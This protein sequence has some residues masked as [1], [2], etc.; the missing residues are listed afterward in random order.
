[1]IG[2]IFSGI[3]QGMQAGEQ[4]KDRR[5][6]R[7]LQKK[8]IDLQIANSKAKQQQDA[9]NYDFIK[10]FLPSD[11]AMQPDTPGQP[12]MP[13]TTLEPKQSLSD[14][15]AAGIQPQAM[16]AP[17]PEPAAPSDTSGQ[18]VMPS[19]TLEPKQ[20]LLDILA[21]GIQPQ[22]MPAPEP[23]PAAPTRA[24]PATQGAMQSGG[25]LSGRIAAM[26]PNQ[27]AAI[28]SLTN[29]DLLGA[30]RLAEQ[31]RSNDLREREYISEE[32]T[33]PD[34][35]KQRIYR[36]KFGKPADMP[37][38]S[39][40]GRQTAPPPVENYTFEKDGVTYEVLR[41]KQTGKPI[42]EPKIIKPLKGQAPD[43]AAKIAMA[44][45]ALA[46]TKTLKSAFI[47]PDG[48]INRSMVFSSNSPGGGIGDGRRIRATYKDTLDSRQRAASGAA[49]PPDE[50]KTYD[51]MY[52]PSPMDSDATIKDKLNRLDKWV[53]D[54]L[55][56][57]DP[58]AKI[59][60]RIARSGAAGNAAGGAPEVKIDMVYNPATGKLEPVK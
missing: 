47:N 18:P 20:S 50:Q 23:E 24:A 6:D 9:L 26:T 1:M 36:P 56:I 43:V 28:Q 14:I 4:M 44:N 17:E 37:M 55:N 59:R 32:I 2:N 30:A 52:F 11:M 12:V 53:N 19:T 46:G 13:S 49:I 7:A 3:V 31:K 51:A 21:A 25:G 60:N 54:Y 27:M 41:N 33:M 5:E 42:T 35:S 8:L 45:N 16:P 39:T 10:S 15:L 22:V 40:M 48:S 58:G 34:G 57:M 29:M 38:A